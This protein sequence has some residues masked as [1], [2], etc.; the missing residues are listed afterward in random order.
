M[1]TGQLGTSQ[2]Q[3]GQLQ[4]GDPSTDLGLSQARQVEN[5]GNSPAGQT[6]YPTGSSG[7]AYGAASDTSKA[8][9]HD[10]SS[11]PGKLYS[12]LSPTGTGSVNDAYGDPSASQN[13][14]SPD[15][16]DATSLSE[17]LRPTTRKP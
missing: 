2:S 15:G 14:S 1:P 13:K 7:N 6:G 16:H 10:A 11:R 17:Q 12:K 3:L 4:P 5:L 9:G 8:F